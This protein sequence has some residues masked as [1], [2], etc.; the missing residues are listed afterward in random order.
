[1]KLP[2]SLYLVSVRTPVFRP[3]LLSFIQS[4][5]PNGQGRER[6]EEV[7][8]CKADKQM[9]ERKEQIGG[10]GGKGAKET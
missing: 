2:A 5:W 7:R 10:G 1:M 9:G 4:F 8:E 3:S 6:R